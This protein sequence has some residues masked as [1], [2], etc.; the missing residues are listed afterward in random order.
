M[1]KG[2]R[3]SD[4]KNW[5]SGIAKRFTLSGGNGF[6]PYLHLDEGDDTISWSHKMLVDA[7]AVVGTLFPAVV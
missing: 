6:F 2:E 7:R 1:W 5:F 4:F 3:N